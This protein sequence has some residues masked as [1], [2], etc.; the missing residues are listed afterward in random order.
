MTDPATISQPSPART[1]VYVQSEPSGIPVPFTQVTWL[2]ALLHVAPGQ[3]DETPV[4]VTSAG[5]LSS[6][7]T[8]TT[9]VLTA[10]T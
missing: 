4:T 8:P 3:E 5:T 9:S 6:T 7:R 2:P 10:L 1:K